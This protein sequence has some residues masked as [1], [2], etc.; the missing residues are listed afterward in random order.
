MKM[1]KIHPKSRTQKAKLNMMTSLLQQVVT[2]VCGLIIPRLMLRSFGSEIYGA[3]A[4]I[5]TFLSYVTL[6]EG[7]IGAVTR[8]ALY[9]AF[10][11]K[12]HEQLCSIIFETKKLYQKIAIAFVLYVFI[13]AVFFKQISHNDS[14]PFLYSFGLVIVIALSTFVEYF[15][16]ITYV[17]LLQADQNQYI[18]TL[19]KTVFTIINTLCIIVLLFL[20]CDILSVK[21]ISSLVFVARPLF[22]SQYVKKRYKIVKTDND[23]KYLENKSSAIGQHIAWTL[24][25]NVDITVLTVFKESYSVSVYSVYYMVIGHLQ[26]VLNVFLSGME[27]VFGSMLGNGEEKKLRETFGYYETLISIISIAL[28]SSAIVLIIPFIKL[29]TNGISDTEYIYPTF[30]VMLLVASLLY[31]LRS[32]YGHLV[33]AAGQFKETQAAAYGEAAINIFLSI[34]LVIRYGLVG[35][36]IG[37]IAA[38]LFRFVYYAIYL[39]KNILHKPF[40][41]LLKRL[42]IN[43]VTCV[44]ICFAGNSIIAKFTISSYF[45]WAIAGAIVAAMALCVCI[46]MNYV[47]YNK[48]VKAIA[49]T[50]FGK[51]I[52]KIKKK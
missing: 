50:G 32:P 9:K 11:N 35:V 47:W 39:S 43:L 22:L 49:Q 13:I 4:S 1:I 5:S 17:L 10:A 33:I 29:Y 19:F 48:D 52:R 8:S 37:T 46:S 34:V 14:L 2:V 15:I 40:A 28:Y 51:I 16:G 36:A 3:T 45:T 31:C 7:G 41:Q 20:H 38:T 26:N 25:N 24:H 23:K 12:S 42:T 21:L 30:A 27:A 6:L 44:I 18:N